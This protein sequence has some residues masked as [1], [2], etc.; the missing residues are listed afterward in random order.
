MA[1]L[2]RKQYVVAL[3]A[4]RIVTLTN[5][6]VKFT[7]G[8]HLSDPHIIELCRTHDIPLREIGGK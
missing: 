2:D 5:L 4:A 6:R 1:V 3:E 7:P 8:Q